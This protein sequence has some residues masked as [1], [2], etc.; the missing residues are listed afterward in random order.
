MYFITDIAVGFDVN[1]Q[2]SR[3]LKHDIYLPLAVALKNLYSEC[4]YIAMSIVLGDLVENLKKNWE[5]NN[6]EKLSKCQKAALLGTVKIV[7][8]VMKMKN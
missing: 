2:K 7:K 1:I 6:Q 4:T 8:N 3:N 5:S